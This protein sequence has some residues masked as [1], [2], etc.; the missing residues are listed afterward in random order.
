VAADISRDSTT[1]DAP[2]LGRD[3][4]DNEKQGEAEH[5]RPGQTVTELCADLAMGAYSAGVVVCR[6]RDETW[7]QSGEEFA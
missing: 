6:S 4:L 5:K 2:D 7:P 3:L 1:S